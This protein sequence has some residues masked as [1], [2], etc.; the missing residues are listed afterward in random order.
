VTRSYAFF[1][2]P[3]FRALE[4]GWLAFEPEEE[5]AAVVR[6]TDADWRVSYVNKDFAVIT[7]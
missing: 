3:S 1:F 6:A 2:K 7:C 5:F 4:D